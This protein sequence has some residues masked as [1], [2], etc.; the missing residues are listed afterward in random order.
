M[1]KHLFIFLFCAFLLLCLAVSAFAADKVVF[2]ANGGTGDGASASAPIGKLADA[3]AALGD[4]GGTLVLMN[5]YSLSA[6]IDL[7][8]HSGKITWTS[9]YNDIDYRESGAMLY[10]AGSYLWRPD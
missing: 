5:K 7:P 2:V 9:V 4:E 1:K 10:W 6:R 8:K 3:Y